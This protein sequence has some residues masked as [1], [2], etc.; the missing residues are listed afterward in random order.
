[1]NELEN[2]LSG[3]CRVNGVTGRQPVEIHPSSEA[4]IPRGTRLAANR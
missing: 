2:P 4:G 3:A 1:M